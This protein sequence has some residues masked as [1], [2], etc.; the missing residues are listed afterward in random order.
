MPLHMQ[1]PRVRF[2]QLRHSTFGIRL[3]AFGDLVTAVADVL[4][5]HRS[6]PYFFSIGI[7]FIYAAPLMFLSPR[8]LSGD[9]TSKGYNMYFQLIS[10]L[11]YMIWANQIAPV[12][13]VCEHCRDTVNGCQGGALC[14]LIVDTVANAEIFQN[15]RLGRAPS[16]THL[17]T[18]E[19]ACHFTRPVCE[20]IVGLACAPAPGTEIDFNAAPYATSC[21]AIVQACIYGHCSTIEAA[22]VLAE[23]MEA[24]PDALGASK[25]QGAMDSLKIVDQT[26]VGAQVR[27]VFVFLWSKI[28]NVVMK[29]DA[30]VSKLS[31]GN[32][33]KA[34]DLSVTLT[35]PSK[36]EEFYEMVHLFVMALVGLG[37]T[38]AAIAMKFVDSVVYATIRMQETWQ[39]AHELLLGY[40]REVDI[41]VTNTI[42]IAN[43]FRRGGQDTLLAE[44]RRSA[45]MFFRI[46]GGEPRTIMGIDPNATRVTPTGKF[47]KNSKKCC[48][49]Y[50]LG[51]DC[52]KLDAKGNCIFNHRCHQFVSDK[53]PA[54]VCFGLHARHDGCD[55]DDTKKLSKAATE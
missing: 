10:F 20:A 48:M 16:I 11:P 37:L 49:D 45:V 40:L 8:L 55:Y 29:R 25:V 50:N 7:R 53:G 26:S 15:M 1:W 9:M 43:V 12:G 19:L 32:K 42:S 33:A 13:A 51:R 14:P 46:R 24:A 3:S 35:R 47:D 39:C 54:G 30:G 28:S 4:Q 52:R 36:I 41:D 17:V 38:Q 6:N 27:G 5:P 23:R 31:L 18:P 44:A 34:S 22:S 2:P 21:Q